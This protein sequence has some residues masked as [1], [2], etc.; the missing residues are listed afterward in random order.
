LIALRRHDFERAA[1]LHDENLAL[2]RDTEDV[3]MINVLLMMGAMAYL[4]R[5]D[6][7]RARTLCVEG[8]ALAWRLRMMP[9][10]AVHLNV[11]AALAGSEGQPT[12]AARLC[13]AA[14]STRE[15]VGAVLSPA[16]ER[17]CFAPYNEV[18]LAKLGEA[19]WEAARAEV[20]AMSTQEAVE[21]AFA[22]EEAPTSS[23]EGTTS[24]LLSGRETEVLKLV[25]QRLTNPQIAHR[26]YLSPR[27]VGQHLRSIYRKLGVPSRAAAV[28]EGTE[29]GLIESTSALHLVSILADR[30][31]PLRWPAGLLATDVSPESTNRL[32]S[33]DQ[34]APVPS[35][36]PR[37]KP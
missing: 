12:R 11:A 17:A 37:A 3:F 14:E 5:G 6:Q 29:R 36:L 35:C 33:R 4:G 28:L 13:G 24:S 30:N 20:R 9:A 7:Q 22:T 27:T 23:P 21:Y 8:L 18:A 25:A 34:S 10:T 19:S 15:T 32:K 16:I 26:L 1:A 2:A 31:E